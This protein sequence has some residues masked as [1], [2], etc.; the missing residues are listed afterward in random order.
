MRMSGMVSLCAV[1]WAAG[2]SAAG[3]QQPVAAGGGEEERGLAA[4][5][6]AANSLSGGWFGR[7]LVGGLIG[8]PIGTAVVFSWAGRSGVEVPPERLQELS[9]HSPLYSQAFHEAYDEQRRMKRQE[10]AFVGGML[11]TAAW[12]WVLLR[13]FDLV[14]GASMEGTPGQGDDTT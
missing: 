13:T 7:G 10:S 9:D 3:A 14:G 8:G 4:G 6:A 12:T 11:G 1:L 5:K 2:A